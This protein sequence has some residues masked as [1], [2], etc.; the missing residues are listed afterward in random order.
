MRFTF[1]A[2]GLNSPSFGNLNDPY[3]YPVAPCD[4]FHSSGLTKFSSETRS[5]YP[6]CS[7]LIAVSP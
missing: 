3:F 6:I 1:F 5:V 4:R 2:T 7:L